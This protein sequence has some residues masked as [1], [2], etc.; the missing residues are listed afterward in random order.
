MPSLV[1]GK[2][3]RKRVRRSSL[4]LASVAG[5]SPSPPQPSV[6]YFSPCPGP[7]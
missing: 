3:R 2:R 4:V 7:P 6:P 5:A 1:K